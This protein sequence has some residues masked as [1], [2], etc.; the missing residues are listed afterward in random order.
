MIFSAVL[1]RELTQRALEA[2]DIASTRPSTA[3]LHHFNYLKYQDITAKEQ[4]FELKP[5][6]KP[7]KQ[8]IKLKEN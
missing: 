2:Q 4:A 6:Q 1:K 8:K 7:I 3:P 5:S